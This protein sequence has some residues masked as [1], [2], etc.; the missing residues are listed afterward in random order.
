MDK[1]DCSLS[2]RMKCDM[3]NSIN[4]FAFLRDNWPSFFQMECIDLL[5]DSELKCSLCLVEVVIDSMADDLY[6]YSNREAMQLT[7]TCMYIENTIAIRE[8]NNLKL[9]LNTEHQKKVEDLDE[10]INRL[11]HLFKSRNSSGE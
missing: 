11:N 3:Q 1:P 8:F 5:S 2:C 6:C 7:M 4:K 9:E 10:K